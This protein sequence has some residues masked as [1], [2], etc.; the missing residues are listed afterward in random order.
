MEEGARILRK[1]LSILVITEEE[2]EE[3]VEE[4]SEEAKKRIEY[5]NMPVSD[6][7]LSVRSYNC[8]QAAKIDTIRD[9]VQKTEQDMLKYR[10]F[11]KKSLNEIKQILVEMNLSFGMELEESEENASS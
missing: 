1:Y 2:E 11:G 8:L 5:L 7:E 6:L 9:L 4:L 3:V 10:N